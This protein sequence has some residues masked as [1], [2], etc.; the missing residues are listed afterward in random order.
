MI[1][2]IGFS[3]CMSTNDPSRAGSGKTK[4]VNPLDYG[5]WVYYFPVNGAKFGNAL[6][7]FRKYNP[8][9]TILAVTSD[10]EGVYGITQGYWVV[11]EG[12]VG[13]PN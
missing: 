11:T 12:E 13:Q 3:G 7:V 1:L 6:S 9:L 5:N 2:A 4:I 8:E 10:S